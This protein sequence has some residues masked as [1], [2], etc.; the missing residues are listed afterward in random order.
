MIRRPWRGFTLIE[1]LVVIA[2][3]GILIALLLP[4]VQAAREA[5][6]RTQCLNNLKQIGLAMHSYEGP[7]KQFPMGSDWFERSKND[8]PGFGFL[9][10]LLPYMEHKPLWDQLDPTVGWYTDPNKTSWKQSLAIFSC[11]AGKR[12]MTTSIR[13]ASGPSASIAA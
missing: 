11:R 3:I 6:R 8:T 2:I 12:S 10:F 9:V 5:A 4:A 7:F 13:R 1:L